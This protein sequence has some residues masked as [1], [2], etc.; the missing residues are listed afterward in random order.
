ML[1]FSDP[2]THT[3]GLDLSDNVFRLV[4]IKR[5]KVRRGKL[6]LSRY[7]EERLPAGILSNGEIKDKDATIERLKTLIKKAYGRQVTRGVVVAMPDSRSFVKVLTVKKPQDPSGLASVV[8]SEAELHIPSPLDELYVDWQVVGERADGKQVDVIVGATPKKVSDAYAE[9]L[10]EAGLIPVA[11]ELEA[12]SIVRSVMPLIRTKD[13]KEGDPEK[14]YGVIDFG[15][16]RSSLIVYHRNTIQFT[17]SIPLSGDEVTKTIAEKLSVSLEEAERTKRQCGVDAHRCG[18][19]MWDIM[20]PFLANMAQKVD[21]AV[22]FYQDHFDRG[23][24]LDEIIISGGGANMLRIDELLSELTGT[25][26]RT[27]DPWVNIDPDRCPLPREII[28]SSTTAVG[29]ALRHA[30]GTPHFSNTL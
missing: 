22:T 21:D 20:H 13:V 24:K 2:T 17:V 9:V 29:L 7:A 26:V 4:Q 30:I 11:F 8:R 1:L 14:A 15:A 6:K 28:L 19:S 25:P 5:G 12:Q 10:E 16:T 18:K 23:K 27:A 3:V